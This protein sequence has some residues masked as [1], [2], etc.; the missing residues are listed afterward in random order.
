LQKEY[1]WFKQI[2]RRVPDFVFS[3]QNGYLG[4]PHPLAFSDFHWTTVGT[5]TCRAR[6]IFW[7]QNTLLFLTRDYCWLW[8]KKIP[9][10]L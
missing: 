8:K 9:N 1:T 7:N 5:L 3:P 10:F 4:G 2:S 6:D